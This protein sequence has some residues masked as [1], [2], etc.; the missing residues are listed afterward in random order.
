[1]SQR[2]LSDLNISQA[3]KILCRKHLNSSIY[4]L[5]YINKIRRY[6]KTYIYG[7]YTPN[8]SL[9]IVAHI[10]NSTGYSS[11][12]LPDEA[13]LHYLEKGNPDTLTLIL[14]RG[15]LK[16][17]HAFARSKM[18]YHFGMSFVLKFGASMLK[19]ATDRRSWR[20]KNINTEDL[21][22]V[23]VS[24]KIPSKVQVSARVSKTLTL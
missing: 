1:V 18:I 21:S 13:N 20:V 16:W 12:R 24:D 11:A 5:N 2:Q 23:A 7:Q 17:C 9:S 6:L 14:G 8:P 3:N 15:F 22:A 10:P 4:I 19:F